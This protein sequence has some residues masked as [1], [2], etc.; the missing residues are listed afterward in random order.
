MILKIV[1]RMYGCL[2]E[3]LVVIKLCH[4]VIMFHMLCLTLLYE[5]T[6]SSEPR[7]LTI[8]DVQSRG[9]TVSW[10]VPANLFSEENLG[11]VLQVKQDDTCVEE[12]I[13]KCSN[14]IEVFPVIAYSLFYCTL[15]K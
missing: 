5:F 3:T 10:I 7:N 9:F 8:T 1:W 13:Y 6:V 14:C 15:L 4:D 11:Y 2:S 12:V